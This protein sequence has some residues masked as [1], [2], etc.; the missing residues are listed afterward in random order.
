MATK[1]NL[2]L[3]AIN[4]YKELL[5]LGR[6][7]PLGYCYFRQRLRNVFYR[8]STLT[9]ECEIRDA[10]KQAQYAKREIETL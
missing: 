7:Y 10:I 6:E 2:K 9:K 4:I 3:Q 5:Y 8:K 1:P